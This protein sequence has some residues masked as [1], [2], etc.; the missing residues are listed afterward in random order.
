MGSGCFTL[1]AAC[2]PDAEPY[3]EEPRLVSYDALNCDQMLRSQLVYQKRRRTLVG[4]NDVIGQS[5][6]QR[7]E[8]G[9][10][11]WD[12]V[13]VDFEPWV[14]RCCGVALLRWL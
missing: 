4:V 5:R 7:V 8:C 1:L 14:S 2:G 9:P 13:A 10:L 3:W 6:D 11:V 12:P